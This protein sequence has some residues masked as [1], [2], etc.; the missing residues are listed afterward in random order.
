[1]IEDRNWVADALTGDRVIAMPVFR[2][3]CPEQLG[4]GD[5]SFGP[6][7]ALAIGSNPIWIAVG[8]FNGDSDPDL[9]VARSGVASSNVVVRLGG[10]GATFGPASSLP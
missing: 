2:R 8:D 5:G 6:A 4:D 1:M 10:P 9:V 7:S 3:L